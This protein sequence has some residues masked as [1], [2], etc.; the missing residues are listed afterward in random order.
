[1]DM[2]G[3]SLTP[4]SRIEMDESSS[5]MLERSEVTQPSKELAM[6]RRLDCTVQMG[7]QGLGGYLSGV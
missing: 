7:M 5:C 1:M 2:R 3:K 4:V 6:V